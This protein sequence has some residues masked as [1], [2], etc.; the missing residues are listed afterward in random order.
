MK[1]GKRLACNVLIKGSILRF[2][3]AFR[4]NVW[5]QKVFIQY[6]STFRLRKRNRAEIVMT[7]YFSPVHENKKGMSCSVEGHKDRNLMSAREI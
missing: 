1:K 4:N 6:T 3:W 5:F 2:L 7:F